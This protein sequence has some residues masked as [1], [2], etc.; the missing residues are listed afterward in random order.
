[1]PI[2]PADEHMQSAAG[3]DPHRH[4]IGNVALVLLGLCGIFAPARAW[5]S[6]RGDGSFANPP[7]Y[8]DY[9]DPDIIRVGD[10]FYFITTT[11]VNTPGLR[12]LHSQDL[13]NWEIVS[14]VIPRIEG[15]KE[16][17]LEGGHAYRTGIFA[18]SLRYH[19]GTFYVAVT[20][21]GQ[22]TRVYYSKDIRGPWRFHELD[23]GAFDPGLFIEPDG[24]A[25]I[26]TSGG[27]DGTGTLLTLNSDLS[28]VVA[29]QKIFYIKGAEGSKVVKRGEWY[30][31]FNSIPS[32]LAL[33]V[34][35]SRSIF[36][37]W[38][39]KPQL[40]DTTGGHQ[41]AIVELPDGTWYGFVMLDAGAIGRVTNISPI[42]WRDDWPVW[43]SPEAPGRVPAGAAKPIPGK[44]RRQPSTSDD[45]QAPALGLQWQWNH[46]PD[47]TRWSL[48]DRP[49][50]LRLR[51]TIAGEFWTARNT[52]TQKGQ[53]P[54]SRGVVKID[55]RHVRP[56]LICGFGTLGKFSAQIAVSCGA[57]D[58]H[59]LG[60]QVRND[61]IGVET[62]VASHPIEATEIFLRT[63]MDF[64]RSTGA[65]HYS[66]DG[67]EWTALGG[68]FP[69][70]YDWRT[71]TF[72]GVQ[73]S[74]FCY[75]REPNDGFA[76]VD[77]FQFSDRP[78]QSRAAAAAS[79]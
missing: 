5:E 15:R 43:G 18:P 62:R 33:T 44:P 2:A 19:D 36:G 37:P 27:W 14:H 72:Q 23:R 48:T 78:D 30:Y 56:G 74:I 8:A 76:D 42:F 24:A 57:D 13:V 66:L 10:D 55:L 9:P 11:F 38:E 28:R 17:N 40:D 61:G 49:G 75:S 70:A 12:I 64:T 73:Y 65:C 3:S 34:S 79:P 77:W 69:L 31:L 25:Y 54:W 39:T 51:P 45:F 4:W 1:M 35:R 63:E 71:G 7:L 41:G 60:M 53:G 47:D 46:N 67:V 26:V 50:F 16:Y 32:K 52:L 6:D 21:V 29:A 22:N 58:R 20:P 59:S 68:E